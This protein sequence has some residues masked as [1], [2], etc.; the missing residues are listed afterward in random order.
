MYGTQ[1]HI[2]S[3]SNFIGSL[4][5]KKRLLSFLLQ[6]IVYPYC[7]YWF[8]RDIRVNTLQIQK[9]NKIWR[10]GGFGEAKGSYYRV[11]G[12]RQYWEDNNIIM[13]VATKKIAVC[14]ALSAIITVEGFAP[15]SSSS[16]TCT[17]SKNSK[18]SSELYFFGGGSASKEDLD[19]QVWV[20][21][22]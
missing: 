8:G 11:V 4:L 6:D 16:T 19:E 3:P 20:L 21:L 22:F 18:Q 15:S 17:T 2:Y 1:P 13:K 14:G 10:R 7:I 12:R 9:A 5:D